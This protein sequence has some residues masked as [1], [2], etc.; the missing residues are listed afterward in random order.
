MGAA[1]KFAEPDAESAASAPAQ[2]ARFSPRVPYRVTMSAAAVLDP[3]LR[4]VVDVRPSWMTYVMATL[5]REV[6]EDE[7]TSERFS[8]ANALARLLDDTIWSE[9][10]RPFV[11]PSGS[12]S[13]S[14]EFRGE[15]VEVH[16][17][18]GLRTGATVYV[19][20]PGGLEWEGELA[21]VPDGIG[22]WAWRLAHA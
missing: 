8:A 11:S 6:S 13:F 1:L 19:L 15:G 16:L 3:H 4:P 18:V 22:K 17:E 21:D 14:A 5:S 10:P 2:M 9:A 12:D 7:P 20:E